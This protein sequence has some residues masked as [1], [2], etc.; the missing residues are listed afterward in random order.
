MG[1]LKKYYTALRLYNRSKGYG[2]HS[3]Y[4][5]RFV[6][7]VLRERCPYYQYEEIKSTRKRAV[8]LG[9][10]ATSKRVIS[11]S[12]AK[13]LFR[14][15]CHFN[16]QA[17]LQIG[18]VYG[19]STTTMLSV[20]Q[21]SRL[22]VLDTE[23][24]AKHIY[25]KITEPVASRIDIE[26]NLTDALVRYNEMRGNASPYLFINDIVGLEDDLL[27]VCVDVINKGGVIIMRNL[28][29]CKVMKRL[30]HDMG[31]A[32][33]HGMGFTNERIG[34]F[35]GLPHLPRQNFYLWF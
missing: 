9:K 24:S 1:R 2:I 4:A 34:V 27:P 35:V 7:R 13:M 18:T 19:V 25:S 28:S 6:L 12:N 32:V 23:T 17:I 26:T 3:P 10:S 16:P 14:V 22:V 15:T 30:W 11:Y 8:Q 20:S 31:I 33:G 21:T 5:F 29:H